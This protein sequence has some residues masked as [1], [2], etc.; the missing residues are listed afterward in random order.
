MR[1][2]HPITIL[3]ASLLCIL[4]TFLPLA[5]EA[6]KC[7][8]TKKEF[9]IGNGKLKTC[10]FIRKKKKGWCNSKLSV[11]ENCPR[12]CGFCPCL[13]KKGKFQLGENKKK[14]KNANPNPNLC[15]KSKFS[16]N[17]PKVCGICAK[18]SE[19][20][21]RANHA[22]PYSEAD[23]APYFGY[24]YNWIS[25]SRGDD[26]N[27]AC[28]A[29]F[30][31]PWCVYKN[32]GTNGTSAYLG[33]IDDVYYQDDYYDLMYE[34]N[35]IVKDAAGKKFVFASN[36]WYQ[37]KNYYPEE[38]TWADHN[39]AAVLKITNGMTGEELNANGWSSQTDN[40]VS[41][42]LEDGTTVNPNHKGTVAVT[43]EC[44]DDCNCSAGAASY[45]HRPNDD[46]G[47]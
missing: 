24:V 37:A 15:K 5:V 30:P 47:A 34:E 31:A 2:T 17:C 18:G 22:F 8:D 33:N 35:V 21:L 7:G 3:G 39:L 41:T 29:E 44:D 45:Y 32:S 40:S 19:C 43:V 25:I 26:V 11:R 28:D 42:H 16:Y 12:S 38:P 1:T 27:D 13:D 46:D 20:V 10:R 6:Q 23:E 36:H 4:A 9:D 14:C